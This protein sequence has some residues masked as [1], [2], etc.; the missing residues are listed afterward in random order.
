MKGIKT[1]LEIKK[2]TKKNDD[3]TERTFYNMYLFGVAIKSVRKEDY[4]KLYYSVKGY[5]QGNE[6]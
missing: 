6:K 3:G 1:M 2:V 4:A 5:L